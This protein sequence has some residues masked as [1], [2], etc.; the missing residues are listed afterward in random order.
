VSSETVAAGARTS[1]PSWAARIDQ[2]NRWLLHDLGGGPRPLKFSWVINFQKA[3]T[4]PVLG[5]MMLYY[6]DRTPAATST[7][8]F[9]YLALHGAY[10]LAWWIKD[11]AFPDPNWQVRITLPASFLTALSLSVYWAFGWLL[12]SGT[13]AARY[14]LDAGLWYCLCISVCLIGCV[15]MIAADAQKYFTLKLRPGLICDGMFRYVRHP[16]YLG[17]MLIYGSLAA[18]VWHWF[19]AAALACI[20][21]E[22][23]AVNMILKEASLS[24]HPGW[25]EYKRRS[26][27]LLPGLL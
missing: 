1:A 7:A 24:R 8:A 18:L 11:L 14:P 15:V 4:F 9:V 12:I 5:L 3:G 22:L 10:G 6:K 2:F 20:W 26:W 25:S 17:E 27:W 16:N 21:G 13:S 23:F 19:P